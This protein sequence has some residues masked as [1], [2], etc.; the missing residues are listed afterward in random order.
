MTTMKRLT[1]ALGC[2][3]LAANAVAQDK[4]EYYH[5]DAAGSVRAV[6]NSAGAV[7]TRHDYFPFG[8]EYLAPAATTDAK[9][10]AGKERDTETSLDYFGGRYYRATTARFTTVDP[11]NNIQENLTDPQR[12]N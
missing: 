8:E 7:A 12:W 1:L 2:L 3:L 11:V 9:G 5:V 10:F 4:I 6:T